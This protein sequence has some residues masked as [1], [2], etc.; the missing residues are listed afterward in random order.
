MDE[1][2]EHGQHSLL[3]VLGSSKD[4]QRLFS[5]LL[6]SA[7]D[8][9]LIV[10]GRGTIV[11]ANSQTE[12]LFGYNRGE[13]VGQPVERLLPERFRQAHIEHRDEFV[14]APRL[15]P[16]REGLDLY[17]MRSDGSEFPVEIS[18]NPI[19]TESGLLVSSSIR[20][21]SERKRAE[22]ELRTAYAELDKRVLERTAEL[23]KLTEALIARVA[24]HEQTLNDLRQSE[25]RFRL[26]VEGVRDHAIYMLDPNGVVVSW[27][28]GA[29]RIFG[30][31]GEEAI[32][33]RLQEMYPT[34]TWQTNSP[35]YA[36]QQ[37]AAKEQFEEEGWRVRKDG[38]RFRA[39]TVTTALRDETGNLR[40]FSRITRDITEKH[41]LEQ[42]L[43]HA[44]KL[45]AVGRLAGGVAH[46]FN[47][48]ATAILGYSSLIMDKFSNDD[49]L[50]HYAEEIHKAGH[51]AAAVTR[52]LLAFSRQKILQPTDINLNDV[53]GDIEKM[54]RRLLGENIR[55]LTALDP[56]LGSIK[57]DPCGMAQMIINL[58][59]N[60]RDAMPDGGDLTIETANVELG[61][62]LADEHQQVA[63]GSYV[64]LRV[65]DTGTGLDKQAA[66]HLFEPFFTTK[67]VGVGTGLG[68]ST[69]YGTVKQSGGGILVFSEP[70]RG[71][72]FEIYLP[73][74][75]ETGVKPVLVAPIKNSSGGSETI[76]V[77]EDDNSLRWLT[78]QIL[79][80]FG[81]IVLQAPDATE[82]WSQLGQRS[83]N[84]DLVITDVIMPGS[85]GRQLAARIREQYP[86]IRL[87]LMS[88]HMAAI[89]Q[90]GEKQEELP[91]LEKPFTPEELALIVRKVLDE[92][93][94]S[95]LPKGA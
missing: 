88:G 16:M 45:E 51:R 77:V 60:A 71:A 27:N 12:R 11:L 54:L 89:A 35:Q 24:I 85:N 33:S 62:V 57:A 82:A 66:A 39:G 14:R 15:R 41:A 1:G 80:Q 30:F 70:G 7:P 81:Y 72:A 4:A 79:T 73:R 74:L 87:L 43:R 67:P 91:F 28:A 68:L 55:V 56:Y 59:L 92:G 83:G 20:D 93:T 32:G 64:R 10:D 76:L 48:S 86:H 49:Q 75:G 40:G 61:P 94:A 3:R 19:A 6:E 46:E 58:A 84:I 36:L 95:Q 23:Q 69:V 53:V 9:M 50:R 65:S 34:D 13:L 63:P 44:Q 78:C 90:M 22:H 18:L 25:E 5:A 52:Q 47:N 31:T 29:E 2:P 17:G 26:L 38:H 37:A 42:Q 21:V 8:A